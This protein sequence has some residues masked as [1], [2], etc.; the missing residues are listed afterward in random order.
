MSVPTD[1]RNFMTQTAKELKK[2]AER[3]DCYGCKQ[4]LQ[5][6]PLKVFLKRETNP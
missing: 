3:D 4:L 5:Y 1:I 6:P 2:H